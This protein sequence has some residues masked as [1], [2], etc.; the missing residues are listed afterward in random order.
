MLRLGDADKQNVANNPTHL[1][2]LEASVNTQP[3]TVP[4]EYKATLS[5][6]WINIYFFGIPGTKPGEVWGWRIHYGEWAPAPQSVGASFPNT[7]GKAVTFS[8]KDPNVGTHNGAPN[9]IA[10]VPDDYSGLFVVDGY[11]SFWALEGCK[12]W[13][14]LMI[15]LGP[16]HRE[17]QQ[18][19]D[20]PHQRTKRHP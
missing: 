11:V 18:Q 8:Y 6:T 14:S 7:G 17:T 9:N 15:F 19:Q 4:K 12:W 16:F 10:F 20:Q 2:W 5:G 3:F 1:D 13:L